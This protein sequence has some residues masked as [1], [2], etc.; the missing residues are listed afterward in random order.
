MQGGTAHGQ[1]I[2]CC[3]FG[4]PPAPVYKGGEEE[5]DQQGAR[6]GE[7]SPTRTPVLVGFGPTFFSFYRRGKRGRRGSRRRKGGWR[8]L[9]KSN[10]ASSLVGGAPAPCGLVSLPPMAHMAHIFPRGVPVTPRYSNMYPIHSETL[11]VSEYYHPIYQSLHL[12]HFETPRH[13]RDL[14]LD[15]EQSSV[16]KTHNS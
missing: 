11:L 6:Q 9:P 16:T 15:S 13:V 4:V 7:G 10:S 1:E 2:V 14:I 5:A 12:N 3:A 8:P